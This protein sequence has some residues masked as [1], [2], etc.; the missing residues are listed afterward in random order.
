MSFFN[1]MWSQTGVL[2]PCSHPLCNFSHYTAQC[3]HLHFGN[4]LEYYCIVAPLGNL[5][6]FSYL[7]A[8]SKVRQ[9]FI[10]ELL[11][12]DDASFVATSRSILQNLCSSFASACAEFNTTISLSKTVVVSQGLFPQIS[13]N[14][15]V[16]Q[17]VEKS[18]HLESAVDNTNSLKSEL[19]IHIGKAVTTFG[20]LRPRVWHN[21]NLSIGVKS[22]CTWTLLSVCAT[23]WSSNVDNVPAPRTPS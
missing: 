2:R 10:R 16:L 15:A 7:R 18:C 5:F 19:D 11:C 21:G 14:G 1:Q 22:R 6:N 13:I 8:K 17:S 12:A 20:Q 23:L 3:S 9:M 4:R